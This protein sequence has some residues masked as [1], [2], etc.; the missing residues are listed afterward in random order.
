MSMDIQPVLLV[1]AW[2]IS[3]DFTFPTLW[4]SSRSVVH[5]FRLCLAPSTALSAELSIILGLDAWRVSELSTVLVNQGSRSESS[6]SNG[7]DPHQMTF[8]KKWYMRDDLPFKWYDGLQ[9]V[10]ACTRFKSIDHR[11]SRSS[12]FFHEFLILKLTD[13]SYCLLE[14]TGG[15]SPRAEAI[16]TRSG[17]LACDFIKCITRDDYEKLRLDES[18]D[19]ISS[20]ELPRE[21]DL[22]DILAIC[23]AIQKHKHSSKYTLQRYNCYFFCCTILVVLTRRLLAWERA[24]TKEHWNSAVDIALDEL[25]NRSRTPSSEDSQRYMLPR[26]C[27]MLDPEN[28]RPTRFLLD[29]MR[30]L[31]RA[32]D[33]YAFDESHKTYAKILWSSSLDNAVSIVLKEALSETVWDAVDN[34]VCPRGIRM[35]LEH[36]Y[37]ASIWNEPTCALAFATFSRKFAEVALFYIDKTRLQALKILEILVDECVESW[38]EYYLKRFWISWELL[39]R[40]LWE[41]LVGAG[42]G[43][44]EDD[45]DAESCD[46]MLA[47]PYSK[48]DQVKC[49]FTGVWYLLV[50]DLQVILS[51]VLGIE[52]SPSPN[53]NSHSAFRAI[54]L[55]T[56]SIYRAF[57]VKVEF[58]RLFFLL[59]SLEGLSRSYDFDL[60]RTSE[61]LPTATQGVKDVGQLFVDLSALVGEDALFQTMDAIQNLALFRPGE[62]KALLTLGCIESHQDEIYETLERWW[63]NFCNV[64]LSRSILDV[65]HEQ[66]QSNVSSKLLNLL[67]QERG[68]WVPTTVVQFQRQIQLRIADH[69]TRVASAGLGAAE[70]VQQDIQ[71]A[72]ESVWTLLPEGYGSVMTDGDSDGDEYESEDDSAKDD[73]DA[74]DISL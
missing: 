44:S 11:R 40:N 33:G 63:W 43:R 30:K 73:S 36:R 52:G 67:D 54:Y 34:D 19:L 56:K 18:S 72:M 49:F 4:Q 61:K 62:W 48:F 16:S 64:S 35:A 14:R 37:E 55:R 3:S 60:E 74:S 57:L 46:S 26:F 13:G 50:L 65:M 29:T 15:G 39:S 41:I 31:L 51:M 10:G 71:D 32:E 12:P 25:S 70:V 8:S 53:D 23:Y 20:I 68:V 17:S 2:V 24:F 9:R 45:S 38:T 69:G 59:E 58:L 1:L 6:S 21:F 28:P 47:S 22:L 66:P 7:V 27:T 5:L 42:R